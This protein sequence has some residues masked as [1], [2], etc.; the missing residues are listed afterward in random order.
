GRWYELRE[1]ITAG[2]EATRDAE[3]SDHHALLRNDLGWIHALLGGPDQA[4]PHLEYALRHWRRTGDRRGEATSLR[5]MARALGELCR[6]EESLDCAHTA[7]RL[8]REIG[9]REGQI[10]SLRATGL[11]NA[12][13]G[14]LDKAIAAHQ[15]GLAL[16]EAHG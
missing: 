7:L 6:R 12:H 4:L 9:V 8:F 11:Q 15:E 2:L 10:D 1:L 14:R 13:L 5:V 16:A 3:S